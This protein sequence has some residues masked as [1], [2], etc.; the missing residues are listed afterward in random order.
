M[1]GITELHSY[2]AAQRKLVHDAAAERMFFRIVGVYNR[3]RH[4]GRRL[5][6]QIDGQSVDPGIQ[7][8]DQI[9]LSLT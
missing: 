5:Q 1:R 6:R 4:T 7:T 3:K 2:D 9:G 8:V